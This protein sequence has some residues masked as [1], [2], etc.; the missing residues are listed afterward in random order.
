MEACTTQKLRLLVVDDEASIREFF[1]AF[2]E[3]RGDDFVLAEN[4]QV[5]LEFLKEQDFDVLITDLCMPVISGL[6]LIRHARDLRP[7]MVSIILTGM[8]TR[9]DSILAIKEGVYDY[10]EKPIADYAGFSMAID[11]AGARS[12]LIRERNHLLRDLQEQNAKL[13]AN[14]EN[15]NEAYERLMRQEKAIKADLRQAQRMQHSMLPVGFPALPDVDIFGFYC[16][17][18][19]LGGDFFDVIP[20]D[21]H[22]VAVYLADVAGHGVRSA[23]I[24]VIIRELIHSEK[25]LK[26][27]KRTFENPGHTLRMLNRGLYEERLNEPIHVTMAYAVVDGAT[28]HILYGAAGHPP[29]LLCASGHKGALSIAHGPALGMEADPQYTVTPLQLEKDDVLFLYSDGLTEA[30]NPKGQPL[31][32]QRLMDLVATCQG[33][34][35]RTLG[36]SV[37]AILNDHLDGAAPT[38]DISFLIIGKGAGQVGAPGALVSQSVRIRDLGMLRAPRP[39][40]QVAIAEGWTG[41][42]CV[43]R[44]TGRATWTLASL[45]KQRIDDGEDKGAAAIYLDLSETESL[46]STMLGMLHQ[47]QARLILCQPS[48][49]VLHALEELGI[50]D[51]LRTRPLPPP[52]VEMREIPIRSANNKSENGQLILDAHE[53]LIKAHPDNEARFGTVV[54][55]MR[56]ESKSD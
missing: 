13:A 14:Y 50:L 12:R 37:E 31:T 32:A 30:C 46:D 48:A 15:L 1:R 28:G 29:P 41:A 53:A 39:A 38:D 36:Q 45:L 54:R 47:Y 19:R 11:R 4:G 18:E 8:G 7:E 34:S 42:T 26:S 49:K 20:L 56:Q 21:D 22:R 35:A 52:A 25:T 16:P 24:T 10:Y 9:A 5:A 43:I 17:C 27:A 51:R 44:I 33:A 6:E 23:M 3:N 2:L 55:L 40:G